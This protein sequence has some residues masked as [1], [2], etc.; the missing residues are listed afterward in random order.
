MDLSKVFTKTVLFKA[1][2]QNFPEAEECKLGKT[3]RQG[4]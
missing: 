4:K 2:V 1:G 3:V